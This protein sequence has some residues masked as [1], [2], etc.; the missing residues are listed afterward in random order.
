MI[1]NWR[2]DSLFIGFQTLLLTMY[3]LSLL[4]KS[5]SYQPYSDCKGLDH[6]FDAWNNW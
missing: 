4:L 5:Q 3:Y 2:E 1:Q 6:V